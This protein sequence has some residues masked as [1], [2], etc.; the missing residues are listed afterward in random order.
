M[1]HSSL[2]GQVELRSQ[3]SIR[4]VIY[5]RVS[6]NV[7]ED[8]YSFETQIAACQAYAEQHGMVVIETCS[9][10]ESGATL[11]RPEIEKIRHLVRARAIDVLLV[12][13][14]DRFS[15]SLVDLLHL[16][17]ELR[18]HSVELHYATRG[19]SNASL[20]GGLFDNIEGAFAEYER[21]RIKERLFR[22]RWAKIKGTSDKPPQ[23]Y[24][25][26]NC[27]YGYRYIGRKKDRKIVVHDGEAIIIRQMF[28]WSFSGI[29]VKAIANRLNEQGSPTPAQTGRAARTKRESL[30]WTGAMVYRILKNEVYAGTMYFNKTHR[31]GTKDIPHPHDEWIPV[32]VPAIVEPELFAAV[33]E[34]LTSAS[35]GSKRNAKHFYLL[36][37]ARIKCQCG[38]TMSGSSHPSCGGKYSHR[39][40]RCHHYTGETIRPCTLGEISAPNIEQ[41]V[42][43]WLYNVLTP[44]AIQEGIEAHQQA[45]VR[46]LETLDRRIGALE[47]RQRELDRD[48][49]KMIAAYKANV[50]SLDEL[51]NDKGFVD[52]ERRSIEEEF[53]RLEEL[54]RDAVWFDAEALKAEAHDLRAYMP[55]MNDEER[56]VLLERVHLT[57]LRTL[58][59]AGEQVIKVACRLGTATLL[60]SSASS[61]QSPNSTPHNLSIGSSSH[62]SR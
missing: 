52:A 55:H 19:A 30:K 10:V 35:K 2:S 53:T 36:G 15:R 28:T 40:Y 3:M 33:G 5:A 45:T 7:Q 42:W 22:G 50:I 31:I 17:E 8:N 20:E 56:S 27:P 38:Y 11:N 58:N 46:E 4:A 41:L 49:E 21:G 14:L 62:S 9:E 51:A 60:L 48:A 18:T 57:V 61:T 37:R 34:R 1:N 44:E 26:G 29:S 47:K 16:K 13:S 32:P 6:T 24:G 54:R 39:F 23:V 59:D 43:N 12:Y 25:N